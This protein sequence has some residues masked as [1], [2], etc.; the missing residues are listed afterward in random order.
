MR[1]ELV[2]PPRLVSVDGRRALLMATR[3]ERH[4]VQVS[5]GAGLNT[6]RWVPTAAV[7]PPVDAVPAPALPDQPALPWVRSRAGR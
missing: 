1:L 2:T 3:G 4:Y 6:L 7:G 5:A